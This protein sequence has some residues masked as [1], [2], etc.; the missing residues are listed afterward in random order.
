M[1]DRPAEQ[2]TAQ[3]AAA[4]RALKRL[5]L[6]WRVLEEAGVRGAD[7]TFWLVSKSCPRPAP[8]KPIPAIYEPE[9]VSFEELGDEFPGDVPGLNECLRIAKES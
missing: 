2:I 8:R 5:R 1:A 4:K 7:P 3:I 9:I 6:G